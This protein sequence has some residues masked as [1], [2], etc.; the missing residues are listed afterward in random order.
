MATFNSVDEEKKGETISILLKNRALA[1]TEITLG[2]NTKIIA[3]SKQQFEGIFRILSARGFL[4]FT[5]TSLKATGPNEKQLGAII[6]K[7]GQLTALPL[8]ITGGFQ[9]D[10]KRELGWLRQE[11]K[12]QRNINAIANPTQFLKDELEEIKTINNRALATYN[13]AFD[14]FI[15][16]GYKIEEAQKKA[17]A[18]AQSFKSELMKQHSIDYNPE[19][20]KTVQGTLLKYGNK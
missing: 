10:A 8:E 18:A 3:P 17:M 16:K 9:Q 19:M 13:E 7:E 5:G 2:D 11:E 6:N 14:Q 20:L 1:G 12:V 4:D 15:S